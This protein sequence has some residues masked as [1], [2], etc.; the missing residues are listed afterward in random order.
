MTSSSSAQGLSAAWLSTKWGIDTVRIEAMRRAGEL[1]AVRP[2]G[3]HEWRFPA[4][5]F[6]DDG[7]VRPD[8]ERLL[9]VARA[10]GISPD[11]LGA[12]LARRSGLTSG[13]RLLDDLLAGRVEHVIAAIDSA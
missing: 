11:R 1:V 7:G 10:R 12:L 9:A 6:G 4:W 3:S 2:A 5:Q 13:E 8:V